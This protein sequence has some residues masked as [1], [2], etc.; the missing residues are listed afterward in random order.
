MHILKHNQKDGFL[1]V[2]AD[3][4]EDLWLLSRLINPGDAIRGSTERKL[5][6]GGDDA[7]NQKVV[8]K[9]MTLTLAT[10]KAVYEHDALRV[11]GTITDGPD[12]IARGDHHSIIIQPGDE[13]KITKEWLGWQLDKIKEATKNVKE[14]ILVVLFDREEALFCRLNNSGHDVI[15]RIRGEVAKKGEDNIT[16][17]NFWKAITTQ[18]AEYDN[19]YGPK[20]IIAASPAFWK[21]YL[22][23]ALDDALS[24]KTIYATVSDTNEQSLQELL[25]RPEV[26]Q[27]LQEDRSAHEDGLIQ[28]LLGAVA[29]DKAAYGIKEVEE[30]ADEGNLKTLLVSDPYMMQAREKDTYA[31]VEHIMKVAEQGNATIT[32]IASKEASKQLDGLGGI[33]GLTRW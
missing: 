28:E 29:K 21:D 14:N 27:A 31:H 22:K 33:A 11:L 23:E 4:P 7:R 5:K 30:K 9:K 1:H 15:S 16:T 24:K 3:A 26:K 17:K 20:N 13:L 6:I 18:L 10:E 19:R 2:R 32:I 8:R 25:R 12:D